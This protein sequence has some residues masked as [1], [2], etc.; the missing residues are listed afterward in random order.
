MP[1]NTLCLY[2]LALIKMKMDRKHALLTAILSVAVFII[3]SK[4]A[5]GTI[6]CESLYGGGEVCTEVEELVLDKKVWNPEDKKFEDNLA[7]ITPEGYK[8]GIGERV[9][10]RIKI[11]NNS[12]STFEKVTVTDI[13]PPELKLDS[14]SLTFDILDLGPGESEEKQIE[15]IVVS[16][17]SDKDFDCDVRNIVR[18]K[19]GGEEREDTAKV[20]VTKTKKVLGQTP[21]TGSSLLFVAPLASIAGVAGYMLLRLKK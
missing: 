12:N 18:A 21:A 13:L 20:C 9:I 11:V 10:F 6:R 4:N 16:T 7:D 2:Y 17:E 3:S 1:Y 15:T 14:G 19:F 5:F 8:F